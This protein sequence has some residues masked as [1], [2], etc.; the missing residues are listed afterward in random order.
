MYCCLGLIVNYSGLL[1]LLVLVIV[2]I[3]FCVIPESWFLVISISCAWLFSW[4]DIN[5]LVCG[6]FQMQTCLML[7]HL[8]NQIMHLLH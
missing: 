6:I 5:V 4:C 8:Q 2:I 7:Q 1:V 3:I